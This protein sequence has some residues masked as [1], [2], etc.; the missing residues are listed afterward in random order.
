MAD[1]FTAK[2]T[3]K[4]ECAEIEAIIEDVSKT[5]KVQPYYFG[6]ILA[7]IR[8]I[9]TALN[10]LELKKPKSKNIAGGNKNGN[11]KGSKN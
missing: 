4:E 1:Y 11:I 2:D 6:A 3:I 7:G 8:V 5:Y 9:K 10:G